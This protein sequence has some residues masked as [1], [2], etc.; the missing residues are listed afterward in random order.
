[1]APQKLQGFQSNAAANVGQAPQVTAAAPQMAAQQ[2][3]S[4]SDRLTQ[5]SAFMYN[6]AGDVAAQQAKDDALNDSAKGVDFHRESVYTVYGKAYNDTLSATYASNADIAI[7]KKSNELA[8]EYEHD[9]VG[10]SEAI[11]Q[12]VGKMSQKAPTPELNAVIGISGE[13]VKN[14]TFGKLMTVQKHRIDASKVQSFQESWDLNTGQVINLQAAGKNA[15]ADVLIRKSITHLESLVDEGLIEQAAADKLIYDTEFTLIHGVSV[16]KMTGLLQQEDLTAA[17]AYLDAQTAENRA[18]M[19]VPQNDK[20]Q[21]DLAKLYNAEVRNRKADETSNKERANLVIKKVNEIRAL[22][23]EP[24]IDLV[25][26][27]EALKSQASLTNQDAYPVQKSAYDEVKKFDD[28]S[29]PDKEKYIAD[30]KK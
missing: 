5:F 23:K 30:L 26:E 12:Y 10:Y 1:M 7:N 2:L 11:S 14:A 24:P 25:N 27:A 20:H 15:D 9:P 19:D 22:G 8:L 21:G 18:D 17:K 29:I 4:L 13:K 6:K 3:A 16:E 28:K